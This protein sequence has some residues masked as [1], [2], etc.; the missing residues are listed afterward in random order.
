MRLSK[1]RITH[2]ADALLSKLEGEQLLELVGPK[3]QALEALDRAITEEL[4]VE[5]RVN[6]EVRQL[7]KGYQAEIEQGRVDEQKMFTMALHLEK[8]FTH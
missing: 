3:H 6:A 4:S 7:L 1:E 5:D 2:L 8:G